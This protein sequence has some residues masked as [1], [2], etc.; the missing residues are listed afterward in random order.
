MAPAVA[1]LGLAQLARIDRYNDE[2]RR[3]A[4]RW[5]AWCVARGYVPPRVLEGSE[6]A[7]LRYPVMVE[8]ARKRD[9]TWALRAHRVEL[10]VWFASP[11]HPRRCRLP[12]CPRGEE[13]VRRC[14]N[15]PGLLR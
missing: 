13:A 14:V 8:E 9:T 7:F 10:G 12:E 1:A 3:T 6:P 2:R 11:L 4:R 5:E 15:F